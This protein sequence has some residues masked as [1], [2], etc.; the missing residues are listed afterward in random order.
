MTTFNPDNW[1]PTL[2]RSLKTYVETEVTT[3][4]YDIEFSYPDID[5]MAKIMPFPKTI[6]AFDIDDIREYKLGLGDNLVGAMINEG[7][8]TTVEQE[9]L[10]FDVNFNISVWATAQTGGV[11]ARLDV[12]QLLSNLFAGAGAIE[13]CRTV[14][15]GI[16]IRQFGGGTFIIDKI[17]DQTVFRVNDVTLVVRAYARRQDLPVEYVDAVD[18]IPDLVIDQTVHIDL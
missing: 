16:E 17:S 6:V 4:V 10:C 2:F 1:L 3:D 14:T 9:A 15:D 13:R 5:E 8:G 7:S 18:Q 12:M 11:T